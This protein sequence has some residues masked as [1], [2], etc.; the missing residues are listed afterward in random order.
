ML[1]LCRSKRGV[2]VHLKKKLSV[3]EQ[4]GMRSLTFS[5]K[6]KIEPVTFSKF[7]LN[8]FVLAT[9][10]DKAREVTKRVLSSVTL[11]TNAQNVFLRCL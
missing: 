4:N 5:L 1:S 11:S 10:G 7:S 9:H 3:K 2:I 6:H 8:C